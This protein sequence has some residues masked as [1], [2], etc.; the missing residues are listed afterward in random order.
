MANGCC[1]SL[2]VRRLRDINHCTARAHPHTPVQVEKTLTCVG[3]DCRYSRSYLEPYTD[4]SVDLVDPVAA[5]ALLQSL[6]DQDETSAGG[7][8]L[9]AFD[10]LAH[11]FQEQVGRSTTWLGPRCMPAQS[12]APPPPPPGSPLLH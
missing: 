7:I 11:C 5:E 12:R 6:N 4:F 10:L 2:A 8:P 9:Q 3:A 1:V